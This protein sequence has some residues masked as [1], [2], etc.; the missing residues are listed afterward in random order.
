MSLAENVKRL[1]RD[2]DWTQAQ[3]AEA[4]G[5]R[6]AHISEM[7]KGK[8]DPKLSTLYKLM[9]ALQSL[10]ADSL[11]RLLG[12]NTGVTVTDTTSRPFTGVQV[13]GDASGWTRIRHQG[14]GSAWSLE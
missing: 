6:I 1:R 4:T 9:R 8:G 7:E 3:L 5:L 13:G 11:G 12:R 14:G 2:K 10:G